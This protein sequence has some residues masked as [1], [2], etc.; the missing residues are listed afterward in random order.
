MKFRFT[1][2]GDAVEVARRGQSHYGGL[3]VRLAPA[4]N[5]QIATF[6]DPPGTAPRRAWAHRSGIPRGGNATVGLTIL[7]S[8]LNPDYPGD[9]VQFPNLSWV[10]PTFPASGTRY[11]I[12]KDR[13]L[14]LRYRLWIHAGKLETSAIGALWTAYAGESR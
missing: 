5:Q 11:T 13:P 4:Q 10:Q 12:A 7:Q 14:E 2:I 1:A 6:T 9:W 8:T 3:N